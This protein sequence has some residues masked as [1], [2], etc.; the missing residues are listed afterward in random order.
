MGVGRTYPTLMGAQPA[1]LV[2]L[3]F[4][5]RNLSCRELVRLAVGRN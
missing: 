2:L 1:P 3:R 4:H 5:I